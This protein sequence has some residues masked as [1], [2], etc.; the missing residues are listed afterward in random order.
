MTKKRTSLDG[1]PRQL[2]LPL[3]QSGGRAMRAGMLCRKDA[4]REAFVR[5]L[6]KSGLERDFLAAEMSRL[7]G[8]STRQTT[9]V[10]FLSGRAAFCPALPLMTYKPLLHNRSGVVRRCFWAGKKAKK[11]QPA[12]V[13]FLYGRVGGDEGGRTPGLRIA[14]AALSQL[15]YIPGVG[16]LIESPGFHVN[17]FGRENARIKIGRAHV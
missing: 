14:N 10:C 9:T 3:N 7:T 6:K 1:T 12:M 5:A 13:G 15:S 11:N 2:S 16:R 17:R 8:E 4:V